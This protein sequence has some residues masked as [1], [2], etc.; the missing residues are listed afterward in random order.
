MAKIKYYYD[1]DTCKYERI[2][3]SSW[4]IILNAMGFVFVSLIMAVAIT[5]LYL[6]FFDSPKEV[7]LRKEKEE[8]E[9]FTQFMKQEVGDMQ[10]MMDELLAR[11]SSYRVMYEAEALPQSVRKANLSQVKKYRE[12]LENGISNEF[13]VA[14][15]NEMIALKK[16]MYVESKSYEEIIQ[17]AKDKAT[18][19][20][21]I[22]AIQPLSKKDMRRLASGFGPRL[23]PFYK[24]WKMHTGID[25]SAP[26]GTPIYATGDGI[27]IKA[28]RNL[29]GYG[30]EIEIDH[31]FGYVTKYAHMSA[32]NVEKGQKIKRGEII[33]YVGSTGMSKAPHL[34]YEVIHKGKKVNPVHYFR[35]DLSPEEYEKI[36]EQAAI[37]NQSLS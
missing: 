22:P 29:G 13:L 10:L 5:V 17:M 14:T 18:M 27:I 34:H 36:L 6:S 23:H 32:F 20:S 11:D 8:L 31:G 25:L 1:T 19:L 24:V 7:K 15:M 30:K 35:K 37:K 9:L 21:H 16:Q 26:V 28:K 12:M 2:K 3:V 33:G 4:D